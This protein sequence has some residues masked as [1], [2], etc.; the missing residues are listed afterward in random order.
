M[1]H[2][3][4]VAFKIPYVYDYIIKLRKKQAEVIQNYL[5]PNVSVTGQGRAM[6]RKYKSL[7]FSGGQAY[8]LSSD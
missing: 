8:D 2:E 6:H 4:H 7:K 5:N 1:V 3:L